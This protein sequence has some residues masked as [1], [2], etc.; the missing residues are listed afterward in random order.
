MTYRDDDPRLARRSALLR[1]RLL[2]SGRDDDA[3]IAEID[4]EL[5]RLDEAHR[6]ELRRRLPLVASARIASPCPEPWDR[7]DGDGTV[8]H[9]ARCDQDVVD[10]S[11]MTALQAESYLATRAPRCARLFTRADGTILFRDC[12]VGADGVRRRRAA[13][14]TGATLLAAT[15]AAT[16]WAAPSPR[17]ARPPRGDVSSPRPSGIRYLHEGAAEYGADGYRTVIDDAV[18]DHFIPFSGAFAGDARG[19]VDNIDAV[20]ASREPADARPRRRR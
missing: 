6:A 9:C 14:T 5:E 17:V 15:A 7:M 3:R 2:L 4:V 20:R 19:M 13:L 12:T 1:N 8:R 10:L 16:I 11:A 18:L